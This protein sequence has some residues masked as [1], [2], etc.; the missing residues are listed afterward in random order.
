ML[1]LDALLRD[2]VMLEVESVDR[3]YLNA[4]VPRLQ[5][6]GGVFTWLRDV[7]G[8]PI[9]SPAVL[10]KIGTA[11]IHDVRRFAQTSNVP[12]EAFPKGV[13]KEDY[14]RPYI[15]RAIAEERTGVVFI[16]TA[17][18]RAHSYRGVRS[19]TGRGAVWFDFK[20]TQVSVLWFYFYL[21]DP[22][23]GPCF[24][25]LCSYAPFTG[26]FYVNGHEWAK[27]QATKA[28]LE[29]TELNNGF[30]TVTAP[31]RLRAICARFGPAQINAA[32]RRWMVVLP[33]PFTADDRRAG[34]DYHLSVLQAEISLT[35]V[36][37]HARYARAFFE[38]AIRDHLDLG[39]PDQM[40]LLFQRRVTRRTQGRFRT[41][42][43][44]AGVSPTLQAF[45]KHSDIKQYL[46]VHCGYHALR[47]ETTINGT[48]DIGVGRA[49]K[50]LPALI[51]FGRALNRRLLAAEVTSARCL[52]AVDAVDRVVQPTVHGRQRVSALHFGEPRARALET[53][54]CL[55]AF[56]PLAPDGFRAQ[57]L[58]RVIPD[59]CGCATYSSAAASYDLRRLCRKGFIERQ[60]HTQRY[61][62]TA[63]GAR[64]AFALVKLQDRVLPPAC[65]P[66]TAVLTDGAAAHVMAQTER[67][68]T[69]LTRA[70]IAAP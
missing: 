15:T 55:F 64:T 38:H 68:L 17:Q 19:T 59:L 56:G 65:S 42:V 13:R 7:R 3:V 57:H 36:F 10:G 48:Y 70:A 1:S 4:Y 29:Y 9:P 54:L 20:P 67:M 26:R 5:W 52:A 45:F 69:H 33:Q 8:M 37:T 60:P 58:R 41:R 49:L 28:G 2:C 30:A 43:V 6:P 22:E 27:R 18:E 62:L 24:I 61:R 51:T 11:F 14:I 66:T 31:E 44:T 23:C 34:V 39:R 35:Q 50:N 21:V 63:W 32:F 12:L 53:A 46:K 16:G 47:T 40:A 25:K